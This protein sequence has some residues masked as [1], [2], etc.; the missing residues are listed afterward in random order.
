MGTAQANLIRALIRDEFERK[1]LLSERGIY[2]SEVGK[3][4]GLCITAI[5][6][7]I[8]GMKQRSFHLHAQTAGSNC[9]K[10][11]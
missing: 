5:S 10:A 1:A 9:P 6:S 8:A 2:I 7:S 11:Y 4:K 3:I